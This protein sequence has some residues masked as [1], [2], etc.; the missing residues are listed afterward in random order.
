[1]FFIIVGLV[2]VIWLLWNICRNTND[3][4]DKQT[5]IQYEIVSLE[6]RIEELLDKLP[7][8][9]SGEGNSVKKTEA[10]VAELDSGLVDLNHATLADL[11]ALPKIGKALGQRIIEK[12][13]YAAID[14]LL[15][16]QGIS[17]DILEMNRARLTVSD[18]P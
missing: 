6:K 2:V 15:Q 16:V 9:L 7:E 14:D 8:N 3:A 5:A 10:P 18:A 12:R 1:M 11:V 17:K 4:L 13:P